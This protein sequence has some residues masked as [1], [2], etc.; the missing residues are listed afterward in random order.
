MYDGPLFVMGV[1]N[2]IYYQIIASFIV[3]DESSQNIA[4]ALQKIKTVNDW[5]PRKFMA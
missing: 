4:L 1:R 3:E 2:N 5:K